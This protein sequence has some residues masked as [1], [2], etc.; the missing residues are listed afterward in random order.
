MQVR[1]NNVNYF[2]RGQTGADGNAEQV[3]AATV[4]FVFIDEQTGVGKLENFT[5]TFTDLTEAI[6]YFPGQD[7]TL[8]ITPVV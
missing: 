8:S 6:E 4:S 7:Y 5:L 1:C 3:P 2:T